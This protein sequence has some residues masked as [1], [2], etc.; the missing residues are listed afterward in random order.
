MYTVF[1]VLLL[2]HEIR[3]TVTSSH[4]CLCIFIWLFEE[5]TFQKIIADGRLVCEEA[6][7]MIMI[8][9]D[10]DNE[11]DRDHVHG[12]ID[13]YRNHHDGDT[14]GDCDDDDDD[15]ADDDDDD[16]DEDVRNI[17]KWMQ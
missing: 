17:C 10:Y 13:H 15:D 8:M 11:Y 5:Y 7:V 1:Y 16:D 14:D 6:D 4:S 2:R 3:L 9:I 12:H